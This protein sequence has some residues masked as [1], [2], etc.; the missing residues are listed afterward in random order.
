MNGA[1]SVKCLQFTDEN[2]VCSRGIEGGQCVD[3]GDPE[4]F[5]CIKDAGQ[6]QAC[7]C[8]DFASRDECKLE[9]PSICCKC[10]AV[11]FCCDIRCSIPNDDDVPLQFGI[12]GKKLWPK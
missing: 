12:C 11:E 9:K 4:G 3:M 10:A 6:G 7:F 8:I 1:T 5:V 2:K